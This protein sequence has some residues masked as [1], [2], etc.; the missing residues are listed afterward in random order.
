M[1]HDVVLAV[2]PAADTLPHRF[3]HIGPGSLLRGEYQ[4]HRKHG[5]YSPPVQHC[6][7]LVAG[8][9]CV[10]RDGL[11]CEVAGERAVPD[12]NNRQFAHAR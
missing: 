12:G 2:H 3:G 5:R 9:R 1:Q 4:D 8:R 10:G 11:R 6:R 7:G